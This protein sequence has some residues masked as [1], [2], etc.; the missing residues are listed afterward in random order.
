IGALDMDLRYPIGQ[1]TWNGPSGGEQR[2]RFIDD[3]ARVPEKMRA[4]VR[5]LTEAQ[6]ETPYRDGGWTV[7]QVV[8]HVA[9][10]HMNA[11]I[12]A[13]FA[14][15]E[16]EPPI[17]PYEASVLAALIDAKTA[18]IETSLNLLDGLHHRYAMLLRSLSETDVQ[19]KFTHPE[20]GKL[21]IDEFIARYSWHGKHHVAHITS[22]RERSRWQ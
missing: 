10:S 12:R 2:A 18:P 20:I 1:F 21:T 4:A 3:I 16:H 9:D 6:L 15:T 11:Y 22:L 13:R 19:R 17:K 7:R 14:L 8:H 5:G